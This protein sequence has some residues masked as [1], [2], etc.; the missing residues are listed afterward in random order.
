[1]I[2]SM[3][4]R[5]I[6]A[7]SLM[8]L[9]LIALFVDDVRQ[10]SA[11]DPAGAT[12][13]A[14]LLGAVIAGLVALW[15]GIAPRHVLRELRTLITLA[16]G[17]AALLP[18][19]ADRVRAGENIS[20]AD[21]LPLT[22]EVS[23]DQFGDVHRAVVDLGR[24]AVDALIAAF[25]AQTNAHQ[26]SALA[27][28]R[29]QTVTIVV[30][31]ARRHRKLLEAQLEVNSKLYHKITDPDTLKL[32]FAIDQTAVQGRRVADQALILADEP[33]G[34]TITTNILVA[35]VLTA[36]GQEVG[37]QVLDDGFQRVRVS[38]TDRLDQ[39]SVTA[40]V[41]MD[42]VHLLSALVENALRYSPQA[43]PVDVHAAMVERGM[44]IT[45]I[46]DG[47]G[48]SPRDLDT[49]NTVLR[50][51]TTDILSVHTGQLGLAVVARLARR[52][53]IEVTLTATH[54]SG[55]ITAVVVLPVRIL[56]GLNGLVVH[57]VGAGP[58]PRAG[59]HFH[60]GVRG[61]GTVPDLAPLTAPESHTSTRKGRHVLLPPSHPVHSG[62]R[63]KGSAMANAQSNHAH[64]VASR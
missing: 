31:L 1:V 43:A 26:Q 35:D 27:A 47:A 12:A 36:A 51:K 37:R 32:V 61:R 29:E 56:H 60:S 17:I 22:A 5:I 19:V 20:G 42:V 4:T 21:L 54:L 10:R 49:W 40:P 57:Q 64:P 34:H 16:R 13:E 28:R 44:A 48:M 23:P 46:D 33:V 63:S 30:G 55:G 2:R 15:V 58:A 3:V 24:V 8:V 41:V 59:R 38:V 14:I 9:L 52:H 7:V 53:A 45:I 6:L 11:T 25:H 62:Q 18:T 50:N 39:V